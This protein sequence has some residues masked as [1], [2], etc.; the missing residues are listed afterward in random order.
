MLSYVM[1]RLN[2]KATQTG[3][4]FAYE[5]KKWTDYFLISCLTITS[6]FEASVNLTM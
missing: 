1:K 4:L 6:L 5:T 3:G 2:K